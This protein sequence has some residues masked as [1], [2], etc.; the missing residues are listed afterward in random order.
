MRSAGLVFVL[1]TCSFGQEGPDEKEL[2]AL[3]DE[4]A[5]FQA[6]AAKALVHTAKVFSKLATQDGP[7]MG[8]LEL[9]SQP[10]VEGV[11]RLNGTE[12]VPSNATQE[13]APWTD[14]PLPI[15]TPVAPDMP[16]DHDLGTRSPLASARPTNATSKA[17]SK[18]P[19]PPLRQQPSGQAKAPARDRGARYS[20]GQAKA[21]SR[22]AH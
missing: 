2:S 14:E 21:K 20:A 15:P 3:R 18:C 9:N 22:K 17:A 6:F 12:A 4:Y 10:A 7:A 16:L 5:Q 8:N 1:A 19:S 11:P 13:A